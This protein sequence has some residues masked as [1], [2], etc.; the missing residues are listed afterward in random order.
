MTVQSKLSALL[1]V[2]GIALHRSAFADSTHEM[3]PSQITK[4]LELLS[5]FVKFSPVLYLYGHAGSRFADRHQQ[6]SSSSSPLPEDR[7]QTLLPCLLFS[8]Q[9]PHPVL[10]PWH[11]T[12][13]LWGWGWVSHQP[14]AEPQEKHRRSRTVATSSVPRL[15][16]EQQHRPWQQE[17]GWAI[18]S[19]CCARYSDQA[20]TGS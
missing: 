17:S 13:R 9:V 4:L 11:A 18:W 19:S 3:I 7:F 10:P 2:S 16:Q 14:F 15:E 12:T 5:V 8:P 20:R 1:Y 6:A